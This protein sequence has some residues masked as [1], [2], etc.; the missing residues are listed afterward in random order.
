MIEITGVLG[1]VF[2]LVGI[3]VLVKFAKGTVTAVASFLLILVSLFF[4]FGIGNPSL[5]KGGFDKFGALT[6]SLLPT[7]KAAYSP[8]IEIVGIENGMTTSAIHVANQGIKEAGDL[9]VSINGKPISIVSASTLVMDTQGT[10]IVGQ[11]INSGDTIVVK[12]G[13][14]EDKFVY[15]TDSES[16]DLVSPLI[17]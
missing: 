1:V 11:Y 2:L 8:G 15:G 17:N 10:V 13:D 12:Y 16:N 9:E 14:Y 7:G 4:I 6:D 3:L 5:I